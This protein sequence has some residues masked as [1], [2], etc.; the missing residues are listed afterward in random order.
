MN[1]LFTYAVG[2]PSWVD[3]IWKVYQDFLKEKKLKIIKI[4]ELW[5]D[6]LCIYSITS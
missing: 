1:V 4:N 2:L 5:I 3:K 6:N